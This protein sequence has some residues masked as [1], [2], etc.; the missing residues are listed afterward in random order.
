MG[1]ETVIDDG[2]G[3]TGPFY[4][5]GNPGFIWPPGGH[6]IIYTEFV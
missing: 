5:D 4:G 2:G 1:T 3:G 6:P